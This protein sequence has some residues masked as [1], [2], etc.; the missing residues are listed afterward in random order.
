MHTSRRRC[1]TARRSSGSTWR[2]HSAW[3]LGAIEGTLD[4]DARRRGVRGEWRPS[5]AFSAPPTSRRLDAANRSRWE[6]LAMR[7]T[8]ARV[9]AETAP[10][11]VVCLDTAL[12]RVTLRAHADVPSS[13]LV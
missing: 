5:T 13:T 6:R 1:A 8:I 9:L 12:G 11:A 10:R 7:G 2:A 3:R 4:G